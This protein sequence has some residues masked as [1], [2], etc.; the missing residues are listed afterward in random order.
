VLCTK[1]VHLQSAKKGLPELV[2]ITANWRETL[3]APFEV[4]EYQ[5]ITS[6]NLQYK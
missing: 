4:P 2:W 6:L 1:A 5:E 3:R